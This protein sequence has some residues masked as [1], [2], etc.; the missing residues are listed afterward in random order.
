MGAGMSVGLILWQF[1]IVFL[2]H[3]LEEIIVGPP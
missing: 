2:L 1:P 3:D